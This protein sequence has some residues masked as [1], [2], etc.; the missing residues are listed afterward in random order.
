MRDS[1]GETMENSTGTVSRISCSPT[2]MG[3]AADAVG[4][5]SAVLALTVVR[6]IDMLQ[7]EAAEE[8]KDLTDK[9][10]EMMKKVDELKGRRGAGKHVETIS[11]LSGRDSWRLTAHEVPLVG[12][13]GVWFEASGDRRNA[14]RFYVDDDQLLACNGVPP[15]PATVSVDPAAGPASTTFSASGSGFVP[16]EQVS[17]WV[18]EPVTL[19]RFDVGLL[20][21]DASGKV[22]ADFSVRAASGT[23]TLIAAGGTSRWPASATFEVTSP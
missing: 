22:G 11:H 4:I 21:A 17:I 3:I 8:T 5:L 19:N 20:E 7:K 18:L 2:T 13:S 10:A 15:G 1:P 16:G 6:R 9:V 12:S 23:W 14:T